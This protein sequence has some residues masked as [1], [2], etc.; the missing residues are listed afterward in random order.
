MKHRTLP[1]AAAIL[2][3]SLTCLPVEAAENQVVT[4]GEFA[5]ELAHSLD[6]AQELTVTQ[7]TQ[8]LDQACLEPM[9]GWNSSDPMTE[10]LALELRNLIIVAVVTGCLDADLETALNG[11]Q[12]ALEKSGISLDPIS[13]STKK[14]GQPGRMAEPLPPFGLGERGGGSEASP[15]HG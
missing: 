8:T 4:V 10:K 7:A 2:M 11:F 1:I 13:F 12:K 14:W 3:L 15:F 6:L 5:R 9:D